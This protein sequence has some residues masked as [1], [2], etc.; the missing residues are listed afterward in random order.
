MT[1]SMAR[2][3]SRAMDLTLSG[4][5]SLSPRI[6][7]GAIFMLLA[8]PALA[9]ETPPI[10]KTETGGLAVELSGHRLV[11]PQPI[12]TVVSSEPV[13]QAKVRYNMLAPNVH[14]IVLLP[15]DAS[16]VTWTELMGVLIVGRPG[17]SRDTQLASV[18]DP[19]TEACAGD[20]LHAATFGTEEK[21]AVV[22]L[23]GR[24]KPSAE[25]VSGRCGGGIILATV[26]ENPGGS[27]KVY[28]EWCTA[29]FDSSN[30]AAWPVSEAEL[31]RY[32][33]ALAT[34][35]TFELIAPAN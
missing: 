1:I 30:K 4:M 10:V 16:V 35:S 23:C 6:V 24:Y 5:L 19:M 28:D 32:A 12:W 27:A 15:T 22:L 14:S 3:C 2:I 25:A 20:A 17:Y 26:L 34:V 8:L 31:G 9:Q 29:A 21:G 18:I 7:R 13:E 33:E 11:F